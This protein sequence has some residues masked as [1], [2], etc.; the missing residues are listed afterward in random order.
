[1]FVV[2]LMAFFCI[3]IFKQSFMEYGMLACL[4]VFCLLN[5]LGGLAILQFIQCKGKYDFKK[6]YYLKF[7]KSKSDLKVIF[8]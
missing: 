7:S 3:M 1:M 2:L 4:G 6:Q 8:S 5:Q